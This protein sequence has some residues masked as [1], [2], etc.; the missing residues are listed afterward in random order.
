MKENYNY[1][2]KLGLKDRYE[3]TRNS[4][5]FHSIIFEAIKAGQK[6]LPLAKRFVPSLQE[7]EHV[8]IFQD[9]ERGLTSSF[10]CLTYLALK[11]IGW[12][13]QK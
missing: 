12:R 2:I 8:S 5:S 1:C 3:R 4:L 10:V 13:C 9:E 11:A 7:K 6:F